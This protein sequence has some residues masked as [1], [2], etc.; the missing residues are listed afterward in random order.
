[1][2]GMACC[3]SSCR[4]KPTQFPPSSRVRY[5]TEACTNKHTKVKPS[6]ECG[7]RF[8]GFGVLGSQR[9][10]DV[11][12]MASSFCSWELLS[13]P[14]TAGNPETYK[15]PK[16]GPKDPW[17]T[18]RTMTHRPL[19]Q[20]CARPSPIELQLLLERAWPS[21]LQLPNYQNLQGVQGCWRKGSQMQEV[22][23]PQ[24]LHTPPSLFHS[25]MGFFKMAVLALS[26]ISGV[27]SRF[28]AES[29]FW[30]LPSRKPW[31]MSFCMALLRKLHIPAWGRFI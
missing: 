17:K 10:R 27:G 12:N 7:Q 24:F 3:S 22:L 2:F 9:R 21:K 1:M 25:L 20:R 31:A 15:H 6:N 16:A 26:H 4:K 29:A 14:S 13:N 11:V 19:R 30:R 5:A 18:G 23:Y 28:L 8:E